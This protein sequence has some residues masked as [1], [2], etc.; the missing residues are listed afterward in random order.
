MVLFPAGAGIFSPCHRVH[1]DSGLNSACY[2]MGISG[3]FP[4][5]K[6]TG[7]E[8]DYCFPSSAAVKNS[9]SYTSSPPVRLHGAVLN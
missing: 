7:R 6:A 8:S 5:D 2:P 4:G 3:S 1:T 9:W